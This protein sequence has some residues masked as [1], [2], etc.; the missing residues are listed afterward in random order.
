MSVSQTAIHEAGPR[1]GGMS[2]A[3]TTWAVVALVAVV[4][5]FFART[6]GFGFFLDDY[7]LARPWSFGEVGEAFTGA[8]DVVG[9]NDPY[10]RPFSTV[11][12]ALEW[13]LWGADIWGYHL[14]NILLHAGA[15]VAVFAL[16][17]RIRVAWWAALVGAVVFA[18]IPANVTTVVYIAERTDAMVAIFAIC[19]LL[20]VHRYYRTGRVGSLVGLNVF[21]V[22]A[23]L[24]KEVA[25]AMVPMAALY[26]WYLRI[27]ERPPDTSNRSYLKYWRAEER[28][29]W[30]ALVRRD[31][32]WL[33]L[34]GP[35]LGITLAYLIYRQIALPPGSLTGRFAET[36]NPLS[37]LIGGINSTF[38]GV[39][40]EVRGWAYG[41]L[42]AGVILALILIPRGRAWRVVFLGFGFVVSGVLPLVFSGGVEPR[43]LYVAEIGVAIV[44]AGLVQLFAT[45][46][47]ADRPTGLSRTIAWAAVAVVAV[48]YAVTTLVTMV[49]AQD[50]FAEGTQKTL[51]A[52][53]RAYETDTMRPYIVPEHLEDIE[54]RLIDAGRID[55]P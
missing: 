3:A 25:V 44:I 52:D 9:N 40:W 31:G 34:V 19:G 16:L 2:R 51:D 46:L 14:T 27:E 17:R 50:V 4:F 28:L 7:I 32:S 24:A 18:A 39:P 30:S 55:P 1:P 35:M 33:R 20:C 5:A 26:W 42:I 23:L 8:F 15:T 21:F 49:Q 11:S 53:Q 43:L 12:F 36:Q 47:T 37:A 6:L 54:Q 13:H 22:L 29:Y 48:A 45:A 10:F 38:K 41:P